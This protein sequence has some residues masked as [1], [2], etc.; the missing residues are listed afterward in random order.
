MAANTVQPEFTLLDQ[1][2]EDCLS[3]LS[4]DFK[5][6]SIQQPQPTA[7]IPMAS[8]STSFCD[9]SLKTPPPPPPPFTWK[10]PRTPVQQKNSKVAV[11]S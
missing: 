3:M 5:S 4:D 10:Q 1:D 9:D 7:P 6:P 8:P 11:L 2:L